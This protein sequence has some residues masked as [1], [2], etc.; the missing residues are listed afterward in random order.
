MVGRVKVKPRERMSRQG[1]RA[2]GVGQREGESVKWPVK[3]TKVGQL[4]HL[5]VIKKISRRGTNV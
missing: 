3:K 5:E 1:E 2:E 4:W